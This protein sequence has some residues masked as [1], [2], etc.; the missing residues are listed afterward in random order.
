MKRIHS[1]AFRVI[2]GITAMTTILLVGLGITIFRQ[3]K[4]VNEIQFT[5]RLSNTQHLMDE[6][7]Y[8]YFV[9]LDKTVN[10]LAN[11]G[12][13]DADLVFDLAGKIKESNEHIVAAGV[14]YDDGEIVSFPENSIV[15]S[16]KEL[17]YDRALENDPKIT[18]FSP[19]YKKADGQI[20]VA[21]AQTIY[22]ENGSVLGVAVLEIGAEIFVNLFGDETSMGDIKFILIDEN[23]NVLLNPYSVNI[24]FKS[25]D[26]MGIESLKGYIPGSFGISQEKIF[27]KEWSEVRK[28]SSENDLYNVDYAIIIPLSIINASTNAVLAIVAIVLAIGFIFSVAMAFIIAHSITKRLLQVTFLLKN[29]SQ[30]DGDLTVQIPVGVKDRDELGLLSGYFNLTIKKIANAMKKIILQTDNMRSQSDSLSEI[31]NDSAAAME[32]VNGNINS[33]QVQ[34][35]NQAK[36]VE[37]T[38]ECIVDIADNVIKL[39]VNVEKQARSVEMSSSSVEEMV[40]NINSVTGIL[41]KNAENVKQLADSAETGRKIVKE[42]VTTTSQIAEESAALIETSNIIRNLA[43]QTNMLAMN[44]A[45]EAAHAGAAGSGFAVV[46]DEIRNLAEDSNNQGKKIGDVMKHLREMIVSLTEGAQKMEKQFNVIFEH[47]QTVNHQESV[48]KSAMD[49]QS[50]GSKQVI[51]AI[52]QINSITNDVRDSATIMEQG[53]NRILSE[54]TKLSA[55]TTEINGAMEEITSGVN[56]LNNSMQ[57]V[58]KLTKESVKSVKGVA[59]EL[60]KFKVDSEN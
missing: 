57:N 53:S 10:L 7:L 22:D 31:M 20:V 28:V 42:T 49:E 45:I 40:A 43:S 16:D 6:V 8:S 36:G 33:V 46:A 56:G 24:D 18:Y 3:V 54:M 47:T 50:A 26:E 17:W 39:N 58:N 30:G 12:D 41:E 13:E 15:E 44:A 51:D 9:G 35:K 38:S 29:I 1:I 11:A 48:I 37:Q 32:Q 55:I 4:V 52:H 27:G 2:I 23:S 60:A 21:G 25:C 34:I 59:D 14:V 19:L 5:E